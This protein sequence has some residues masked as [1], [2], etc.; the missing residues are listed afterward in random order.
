MTKEDFINLLG[1]LAQAEMVQSK[2]LASLTIAQACLESNFGMSELSQN[3]KNLF[4]IK[5]IGP[6]GSDTYP[7]TEYDEKG[8]PFTIQVVFRRYN[9][10]EESITDHSGLFQRLDR[11]SNL[12][13]E[14]DYKAACQKAY[15]DGY[16]TDPGYPNSLIRLIEQ[17]ELW[18]WD[19]MLSKDDANQIA[20]WLGQLWNEKR[21]GTSQTEFHRLANEVRKAAGLPQVAPFNK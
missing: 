14:E 19:Y 8:N 9:T 15:D 2:I 17:Y 20:Y 18:R 4:G 3:S 13:G 11:Y 1:P 7:T 5:G 21:P 10:W 6:A 16:A 12:I